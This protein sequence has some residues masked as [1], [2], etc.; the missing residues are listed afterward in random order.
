M[1]A[2]TARKNWELENNIV[3][4]DPSQDQ[5]YRYDAEEHK[6]AVAKQPW[7]S[8]YVCRVVIKPNSTTI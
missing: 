6:A 3:L 4:V 5:I 2:E 8:E 1:D 7:K